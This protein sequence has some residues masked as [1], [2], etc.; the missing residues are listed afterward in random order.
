[1]ALR[2]DEPRADSLEISRFLPSFLGKKG[3][4]AKDAIAQGRDSSKRCS[5]DSRKRCRTRCIASDALATDALTSDAAAS[6][7]ATDAAATHV[8]A[9]HV[10]ATHLSRD[11]TLRATPHATRAE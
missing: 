10:P 11:T 6:D 2:S 3:V 7:A 4:F 1:M 5:R 8:P 9:T